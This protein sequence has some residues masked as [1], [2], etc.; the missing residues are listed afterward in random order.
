M[1]TFKA[2]KGWACL[3]EHNGVRVSLIVQAETKKEAMA[4]FVSLGYEC[5]FDAENVQLVYMCP[6]D[7]RFGKPSEYLDFG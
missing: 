5:V 1:R 7:C 3:V 4:Q 6:Y 2:I